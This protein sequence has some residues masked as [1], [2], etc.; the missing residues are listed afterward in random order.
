MAWRRDLPISS[1]S[2]E[3]P[4]ATPADLAA[5]AASAKGARRMS[6]EE[7]FRFLAQFAAGTEELRK[8]GVSTG[9][10]PFRL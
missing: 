1:G 2:L 9:G 8:R 10:E 4:A 5:L 3:L 6:W 7:Y